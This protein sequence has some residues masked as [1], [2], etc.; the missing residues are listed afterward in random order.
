MIKIKA[1]LKTIVFINSFKIPI[2]HGPTLENKLMIKNINI[3][4]ET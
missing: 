3:W 4:K 2:I 1:K